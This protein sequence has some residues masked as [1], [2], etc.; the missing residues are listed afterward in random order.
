MKWLVVFITFTLLACGNDAQD[1]KNEVE[2]E[3]AI[4]N[5]L[6]PEDSLFI[7]SKIE[8]LNAEY[9]EGRQNDFGG[10]SFED[11]EMILFK[12]LNFKIFNFRGEYASAYNSPMY[13]NILIDLTL[14]DTLF[15]EDTTSLLMIDSVFAKIGGNSFLLHS[16]GYIRA[17]GL[18]YLDCEEVVLY[19]SKAHQLQKID[20]V[21]L[22]TLIDLSEGSKSFITN[23]SSYIS[24]DSDLKHIYTTDYIYVSGTEWTDSMVCNRVDKIFTYQYKNNIFVL[25]NS[26]ITM[27]IRRDISQE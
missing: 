19:D 16:K 18:E 25:E 6:S 27:D 4:T 17:R 8:E 7:Q 21:K 20:F 23:D 14:N 9:F 12:N 22:S 1:S 13:A 26:R 5:K 2:L 24:F 15:L 10:W 11:A 3:E